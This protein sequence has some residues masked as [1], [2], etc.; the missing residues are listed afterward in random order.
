MTLIFNLCSPQGV[1][2]KILLEM[3]FLE[4]KAKK[5]IHKHFVQKVPQFF[6]REATKKLFFYWPGH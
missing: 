1:K 4:Q 2:Q 6:L 5:D 3:F